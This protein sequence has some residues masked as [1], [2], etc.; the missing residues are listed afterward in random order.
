MLSLKN[1]ST[2]ITSDDGSITLTTHRILQRDSQVNKEIMLTDY[3]SYETFGKRPRYYK[4]LSIL[5]L[6]SGLIFG[7][8]AYQQQQEISS[9]EGIVRDQFYQWRSRGVSPQEKLDLF[10]A[11]FV[12]SLVLLSI[13]LALWSIIK[14][15]MLRISG[16]YSQLEF[17]IDMVGR[18]SLNKFT[19]AIIAESD[20]R[21]KEMTL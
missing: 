13:S 11:L 20:N 7:V 18:T 9:F 8:L 21:K 3:V 10:T 1:E 6:A 12:I 5:F 16:K 19:L 2:V 15:R 17:S 14:K 4:V